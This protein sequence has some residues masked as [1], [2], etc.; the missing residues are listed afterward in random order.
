MTRRKLKILRAAAGSIASW[1]IIH[2]LQTRGIEVIGIDSDRN[3]FAFHL[4][5]KWY[6][7]PK[8]NDRNFLSEITRIIKSERPDAYLTG[9]EEETLVLSKHKKSLEAY[10]M[11]L[12]CPDYESVAICADKKK[13]YGFFDNSHIGYPEIYNPLSARFPCVMKPRFGRGGKD[14][15]CIRNEKE[16]RDYTRGHKQILLIVQEYVEGTEYSVDVLA[17][18]GAIASIVPRIRIQTDSGISVTGET[19]Y[20]KQIIETSRIIA[21]K[22]K[23][24][25]PSCIQ[26][27]QTKRGM[28]KF[29]DVNC[30][31]GGGSVLSMRADKAL[32]PNLLRLVRG[33]EPLA[34]KTFEKGLRMQRYYAEV[35]TKRGKEYI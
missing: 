4:L 14:V 21:T 17:G 11:R 15:I 28:F 8:A 30:R 16:F 34:S 22:L 33:E 5:K 2:E 9:P 24:F 20:N 12:L 35:Y 27:I 10:G 32:V 13:L 31:F 23:L 25:G 7:V 19:V 18:R 1:G 26:C 6:R 29:I 3:A